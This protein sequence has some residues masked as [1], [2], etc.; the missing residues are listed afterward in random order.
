ME[1]R[2]ASAQTRYMLQAVTPKHSPDAVMSL[3]RRYA[4]DRRPADLERLVMVH[5][6]LAHKLARRYATGERPLEDLEQ[7]AVEGLL[8]ALHRFR[9]ELGYAFSTFAVPTILGE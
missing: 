3:L 7:V 6:P 9:P 2:A 4:S 8:K 5:R 1:V